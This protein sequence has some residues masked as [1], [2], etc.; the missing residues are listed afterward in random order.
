[1]HVECGMRDALSRSR[2]CCVCCYSLHLYH[3]CCPIDFLLPLLKSRIDILRYSII[4]SLWIMR[5]LVHRQNLPLIIDTPIILTSL[6]LQRRH[7]TIFVDAA[8]S[9]HIRNRLLWLGRGYRHF[10]LGYLNQNI[11]FEFPLLHPLPRQ[12]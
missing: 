2:I 5:M 6:L 10:L 7:L 12:K 4:G 8:R 1:M 9:W 3:V 11:V